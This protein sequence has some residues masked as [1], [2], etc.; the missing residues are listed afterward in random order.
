MP[1]SR[2]R[3]K[4]P[5]RTPPRAVGGLRPSV[6]DA[7]LRALVT[8][9]VL[10][11]L[12]RSL[13]AEADG[14]V[15]AAIEHFESSPLAASAP[16]FRHLHEIRDL[17]GD[18]PGWVWSRW[19]LEQAHRWLYLSKDERLQDA[20]FLAYLNVYRDVD[21]E[22]PLGRDPA[23]FAAD[24]MAKDWMCR[25]LALYEMGG[26]AGYL[27]EMAQT[28][29][30]R[31]CDRILGWP[32]AKMGAFRI[33]AAAAGTATLAD[34]ATGESREVLN[35]GCLAEGL[36]ACVVG[37]LVPIRCEPGWVFESRPRAVS[38]A[39]ADEVADAVLEE[40]SLR[41]TGRGLA[42]WTQVLGDAVAA[43]EMRWPL[44]T[45]ACLTTLSSDLMP[46]IWSAPVGELAES[47]FEVCQESLEAA[48]HGQRWAVRAG[49]YMSAVLVDSRVYAAAGEHLTQP[50]YA[51]AWRALASNTHDPVRSR[52]LA[53]AERCG[54][55][56]A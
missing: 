47:A 30:L 24:V 56:A 22:M 46:Y 13:V 34:L 9:Q 33:E 31:G 15:D 55:A 16:H 43:G 40:A 44:E 52:C 26:L 51:E 39:V 50:R 41:T 8:E 11:S 53:L 1:K 18:A 35:L 23:T 27:D 3:K 42:G 12:G 54:V 6:G 17:G 28:P 45:T 37:R 19:V 7:D 20:A 2:K 21:P 32:A 4:S 25:Q 49:P 48:A 14:D 38:D 5:R 10:D 36:G 29:L